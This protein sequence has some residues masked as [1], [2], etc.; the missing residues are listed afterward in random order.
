MFIE[1]KIINKKP[2]YYL[3]HSFRVEG[4]VKTKTLTESEIYEGDMINFIG[5]RIYILVRP[6]N[7]MLFM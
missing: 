6:C 4:K 7:R 2:Y 5:S 3:K 1:R